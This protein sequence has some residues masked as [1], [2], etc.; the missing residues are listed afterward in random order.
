MGLGWCRVQLDLGTDG[1]WVAQ[2]R[3]GLR[4]VQGT[5][6]SKVIQGVR[7]CE[8]GGHRAQLGK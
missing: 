5:V 3:E 2:A 7:Y 8:G 1:V 6:R 4:V